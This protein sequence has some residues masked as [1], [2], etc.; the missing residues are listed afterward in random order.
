MRCCEALPG[1]T[2]AGW[3]VDWQAVADHVRDDPTLGLREKGAD[4]LRK[5]W[6]RERQGTSGR[7]AIRV[8][9]SRL[10]PHAVAAGTMPR[11]GDNTPSDALHAL[12]D[13]SASAFTINSARLRTLPHVPQASSVIDLAAPAFGD[14]VT[15]VAGQRARL[16]PAYYSLATAGGANKIRSSTW[17][18]SDT[19]RLA[20]VQPH[21]AV[22]E[23]TA[24]LQPHPKGLPIKDVST[25]AV[26]APPLVHVRGCRSYPRTPRAR[27]SRSPGVQRTSAS[28]PR[29]G[30][31]RRAA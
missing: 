14:E 1:D 12:Y 25:L 15:Y 20:T 29:S 31:A 22:H 7:A 28:T 27:N 10:P 8:A 30:V 21:S 26:G 17:V 5:R 4:A 6:E 18:L 23:Q 11:R 9:L 13:A 2:G 16:R 24:S 3:A 19:N